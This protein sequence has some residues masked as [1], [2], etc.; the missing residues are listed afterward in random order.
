MIEW[1]QELLHLNVEFIDR[2]GY[3]GIFLLMT[4]ESS[5]IPF[6]SEVVVPPAGFLAARGDMD[7][8]LVMA[9]ALGGSLAGAWINY[10]I[11]ARIGRPFFHRYGKWFLVKEAAL[12]RAEAYFARHGEIGTFVGRLVPGVRQLISIPAGMAGMHRGR[13]FFFTGLGAG[14]WCA[15]LL[16]I[17]W[18]LGSHGDTMD[19]GTVKS[20]AKDAFLH[21]VVPSLAVI[22]VGYALFRRRGPAIAKEPAETP[23]SP[24]SGPVADSEA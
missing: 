5:F 15:V 14:I 6:P 12:D 3:V 20:M 7:P 11:A 4:I 9:A 1:I 18:T 24:G 8:W 21:W 17:G 19:L 10:V 23:P 2:I 16:G 13:F 22:V